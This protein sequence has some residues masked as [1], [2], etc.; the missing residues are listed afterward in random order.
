MIFSCCRQKINKSRTAVPATN[1]WWWMKFNINQELEL[2]RKYLIISANSFEQRGSL[3]A[4]TV[5]FAS[6]LRANVVFQVL[7]E[8]KRILK[9][10]EFKVR[11][12]DLD[13]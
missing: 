11:N 1:A 9:V 13:T 12:F 6:S 10:F 7:L 3:C 5:K 8:P 4:T 2:Q